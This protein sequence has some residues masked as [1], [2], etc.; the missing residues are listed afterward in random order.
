MLKKLVCVVIMMCMVFGLVA[1][2]STPTESESSVEESAEESAQESAGIEASEETTFDSMEITLSTTV[3]ETQYRGIALQMFADYISEA[4]DGQVNVTI[5]YNSSAF[6]QDAEVSSMLAGDLDMNC[7][8]GVSYLSNDMPTLD[9]YDSLYLFKS[10]DQMHTFYESDE[11]AEVADQCAD[12]T[13]IRILE[14]LYN[15]SRSI[16]LTIDRKVTCRADLED[17]KLRVSTAEVSILIGEALGANPVPMNFSEVYLALQT[18]AADGQE[19]GIVGITQNSLHEVT[20]SV[21]LSNHAYSCVFLGISEEKWQSFSPELQKI[22]IDAAKY[23]QEYHDEEYFVLEEESYDI[24]EDAGISVYELTD[25]EFAAY[26]QE[27]LDFYLANVD[28]SDWDMDVYNFIQDM[29]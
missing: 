23:A 7:S 1:C 17:I 25:E 18:G 14:L 27:V 2:S 22:F 26:R 16:N 19:N 24:L 10:Y 13:G 4:T 3:P 6:V 9:M 28:T 8:S 21:T 15:G 20:K 29:S 12:E 11:W 5:Y